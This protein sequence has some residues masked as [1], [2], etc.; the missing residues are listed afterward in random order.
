MDTERTNG[1]FLVGQADTFANVK[2][3]LDRIPEQFRNRYSVAVLALLVWVTLFDRNDAWTTYKNRRTLSRM[4][5]QKE[6]YSSEIARTKEQLHELSS[7][8]ELLE[9]F[10][11]ERYLM[12][13]D[14]EDIFV[15]VP[16]H[17]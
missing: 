7:D 15:L 17:H 5:E 2:K 1:S 4:H 8:K 12:K 3:L 11:R 13:R 14:N 10:A 16:E 9:K 6:W